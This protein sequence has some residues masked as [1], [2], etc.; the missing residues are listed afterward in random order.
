MALT[1]DKKSDVI[2]EVSK[3]L[4][5]SKLTVFAKYSGTSVKSLQQLR[6]DSSVN[7]TKV[8][9]VKNRLFKKAL[10]QNDRLKTT[11]LGPLSGQLI[12]AF[13][14]E[15]EVAP[16]QSLAAFAKE[17]PQLEFVGGLMADGSL[18]D[19]EEVKTLAK[20]PGK[21]QLVA[22]AVAMLLSP[23]S[24]INIGLSGNLHGLLDGIEAKA[25]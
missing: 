23:V 13:N 24:D 21:N 18:L 16:A 19:A 1:R 3:L 14:A 17:E 7:G 5:E 4:E 12:Y 25:A 9:V 20:L 2:A 10:Q 11:D 8:K 6:K 22:E 15:D